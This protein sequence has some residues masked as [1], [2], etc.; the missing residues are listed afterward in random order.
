MSGSA[1]APTPPPHT[2]ADWS[3]CRTQCGVR[4]VAGDACAEGQMGLGYTC[5]PCKHGLEQHAHPFPRPPLLPKY[6]RKQTK[7]QTFHGG[8]RRG[9]RGV[10]DGRGRHLQ[11]HCL[12]RRDHRLNAQAILFSVI[13]SRKPFF[14]KACLPLN[15]A[16]TET[17]RMPGPFGTIWC[18]QGAGK[19]PV[20]SD[21]VSAQSTCLAFFLRLKDCLTWLG[22]APP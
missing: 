7:H 2:I 16:G 4:C 12:A 17:A 10:L 20:P 9:T 6:Q 14:K 1:A 5:T 21:K 13:I 11:V 22:A 15:P 3:A 19:A 8:R 18:R